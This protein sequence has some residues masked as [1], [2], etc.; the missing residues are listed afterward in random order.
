MKSVKKSQMDLY[1]K[2]CK[3]SNTQRIKLSDF[4]LQTMQDI[5]IYNIEKSVDFVGRLSI[6]DVAAMPMLHIK[7]VETIVPRQWIFQEI[8]DSL[9]I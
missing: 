6:Q 7:F 4:I 3:V 5:E 2:K 1:S 9:Q 8:I